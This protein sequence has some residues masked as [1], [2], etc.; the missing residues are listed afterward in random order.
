MKHLSRLGVAALL[1][2]ASAVPAQA[3]G[4][5]WTDRIFMSVN[6]GV[7]PTATTFD[8]NVTFTSS[9]EQGD[10]DVAYDV[11]TAPI[12]DI[13]GGARLWRNLGVGVA[14]SSYSKSATATVTGRV[15]HPFFFDRRRDVEADVSGLTRDEIGVH[16]Q[17]LWMIP[18]RDNMDIAVFGGPSYMRVNQALADSLQL[19]EAFPFDTTTLT[20]VNASTREKSA[21]G[22]NI[23]G[24]FTYKLT[25]LIGVGGMVRISHAQVSLASQD[26]GTVEID[27]GG[28][29]VA[30]GLRLRF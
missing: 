2:A 13:S 15:P 21:V 3:Q 22:F 6:G 23:G 14:V 8:D 24:D 9:A 7:R 18:V 20:G 19:D 25:K 29:H 5:E 10:F 30:A 12:A 17:A 16:I 1:L 27:L 26:G 11:R 4:R 28:A